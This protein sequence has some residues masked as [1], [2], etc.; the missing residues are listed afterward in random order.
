MPYVW[1]KDE[2]GSFDY[3][4]EP[5][6]HMEH[7]LKTHLIEFD[8]LS[9]RILI[10]LE[11]AGIRTLGDLINYEHDKLKLI[12]QLG[13]LSIQKIDDLLERLDLKMK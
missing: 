11:S 6:L 7:L 10:L 1:K 3:F 2:R 9:L 8:A 13:K 5:R 4:D 12:P